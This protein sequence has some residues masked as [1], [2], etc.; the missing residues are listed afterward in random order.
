MIYDWHMY[1]YTHKVNPS[2][3]SLIWSAYRAPDA[4][5]WDRNMLRGMYSVWIGELEDRER[6]PQGYLESEILQLPDDN[7]VRRAYEETHA[8]KSAD[9][10]TSSKN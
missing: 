9:S 2:F 6:G 10:G 3:K 7:P 5:E 1:E 4:T 8:S